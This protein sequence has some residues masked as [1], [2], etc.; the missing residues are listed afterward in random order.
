M[1]TLRLLVWYSKNGSLPLGS[2]APK[3]VSKSN[4]EKIDP[5]QGTLYKLLDSSTASRSWKTRKDWAVTG[6][7]RS[8]R[9]EKSVQL[10]I[11]DQNQDIKWNNQWNLGEVHQL[12]NSIAWLLISSFWWCAIVTEAVNIRGSW[13]MGTQGCSV[14]SFNSSV[15]LKLFKN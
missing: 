4:Y 7:R 3:S 10:G 5:N 11:L 6:W 8:K 9:C 13:L 2:L 12:A 1:G 14:L 15:S